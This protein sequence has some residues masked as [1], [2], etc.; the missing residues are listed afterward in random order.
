MH[1][2]AQRVCKYVLPYVIGRACESR[3]P[4]SGEKGAQVNCF[5]T[6][7]DRA[8]DPYLIVLSLSGDDLACI[9]WDGSRYSIDQTIPL[10]S[11]KLADFQITHYYGHSQIQY[12]GLVDFIRN[13]VIPWPYLKIYT[14]RSLSGLGQYLFNKKK[15]IT[16]QRNGLLRF[17]I[18]RT[19]DGKTEH[20]PLDLMTGLYGIKW[21]LHPHG[22]EQQRKVEFY[23]DGLVE[24]GELRKVNYEYIVTGFAMR[25]I[26][27]DEENERKHTES[28]KMQWRMFWLTLAILALTVV[29]AGLVKLPVW[30]D[31]TAK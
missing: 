10:G 18:D 13:R 24:T 12:F 14:A 21:V 16:K 7:I 27:Q 28:V 3:I 20:R 15:L 23:L 30:L 2:L 4:R 22:D 8:N 5:V 31:L 6:A 26:E 1:P 11:L 9:E 25:A 19:L 29:Q 17:L